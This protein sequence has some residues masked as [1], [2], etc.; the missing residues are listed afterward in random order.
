MVGHQIVYEP[1]LLETKLEKKQLD[2][3]G[4]SSL[5]VSL[6][7]ALRRQ[8]LLSMKQHRLRKRCSSAVKNNRQYGLS[9]SPEKVAKEEP[10]AEELNSLR[11]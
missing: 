10:I 5:D 3:F 9:I 2:V 8:S 4:T 11:K 1:A 6:T 7:S